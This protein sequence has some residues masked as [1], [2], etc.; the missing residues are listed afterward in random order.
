M[1]QF[2]HLRVEPCS[3]SANP[4]THPPIGMSG[5]D[6]RKATLPPQG[7][8]Q[9]QCG[10]GAEGG[11]D[12]G[13]DVKYHPSKREEQQSISVRKGSSVLFSFKDR[14]IKTQIN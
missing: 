2:A 9:P 11:I 13:K 5:N 10:Y 12:G 14:F 6:R 1:L 7:L 4:A 3:T 8:G